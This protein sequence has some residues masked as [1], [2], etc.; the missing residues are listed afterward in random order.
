[1]ESEAIQ[2][3]ICIQ[4]FNLQSDQNF[5]YR[6]PVRLRLSHR[7]IIPYKTRSNHFLSSFVGLPNNF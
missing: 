4:I 3:S 2:D 7:Y 1:M 6:D 5:H